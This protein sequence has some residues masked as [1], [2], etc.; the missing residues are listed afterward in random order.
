M[1]IGQYKSIQQIYET[2]SKHYKASPLPES[3]K[4]NESF[5]VQLSVNA[6]QRYS[7]VKT[8]ANNFDPNSITDQE[9]VDMSFQLYQAGEID[10][11]QHAILS[12]H[13]CV[14]RGDL[15]QAVYGDHRGQ[16]DNVP[17]DY[18]KHFESIIAFE[19]SVG[20]PKHETDGLRVILDKLKGLTELRENSP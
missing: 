4:K 16:S 10:F 20:H 17:R 15:T 7:E 8:I 18:I 3:P 13:A 11:G 6:Q 12:R 5:V 9:M 19:E 14:N 1:Q 2:Q